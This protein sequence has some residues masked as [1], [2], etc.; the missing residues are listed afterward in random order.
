MKNYFISG[1]EAKTRLG[2][3][4]VGYCDLEL[5]DTVGVVVDQE[6]LV[7]AL[8]ILDAHITGEV[9]TS[10][11]GIVMVKL[12]KGFVAPPADATEDIAPLAANKVSIRSWDGEGKSGFVRAI[13]EILLPYLKVDVELAVPHGKSLKATDDGKFHIRIW[14]SP[15]GE[16]TASPPEVIWGIKT[17]CMDEGYRPTGKGIAIIDPASG[18]AVAE[19]V[20]GNNLYVHHDICHYGT[21]NELSV[22]RRL[23]E[24]TVAALTLSPEERALRVRMIAEAKLAKNREAYVRECSKRFDKTLDNSKKAVRNGHKEIDSLQQELVRLIRETAGAERKVEQMEA[25][26]TVQESHYLK[27][28][29]SL[30]RVPGVEDVQVEEG[31]IK[32]FT[33]HI[34]LQPSGYAEIFDIGKFRI[35][36]YT[37]GNNGGIRFYNITSKGNGEKFNIHHP[38]VDASGQACLGNIK[39]LVATLIGEYEYSALA[40]LAIQFLKSVNIGDD[41]GRGIFKY[42]PKKE[43]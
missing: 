5:D 11:D 16:R 37:A 33:D 36:I 25:S 19:L 40:Q 38:H 20:G 9:K 18:W 2:H 39:E 42:W 34:C 7:R 12:K 4:G 32:V 17:G 14:S 15:K 30:T 1:W 41:A 27:E 26:K 23:L 10:L 6:N 29:E 24:E 35:D 13:E 43:I 21:D 31:I 22:F 3:A 28:F 8:E